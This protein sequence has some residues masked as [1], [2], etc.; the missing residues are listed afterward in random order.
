MDSSMLFQTKSN[1]LD[2]Q[3][4]IHKVE[5][6]KNALI[7]K[8]HRESNEHENKIRKTKQIKKADASHRKVKNKSRS[9]LSE[10]SSIE[11]KAS[12]KSLLLLD[13]S[14]KTTSNT[15]FGNHTFN[16]IN[17]ITAKSKFFA[18][19][20]LNNG[21]SALTGNNN[22]QQKRIQFSTVDM[23][24]NE[25]PQLL[26]NKINCSFSDSMNNNIAKVSS[27][28][29]LDLLLEFRNFLKFGALII[30][31]RS[32]S[33]DN[34]LENTQ[35]S[36]RIFKRLTN[37]QTS[38]ANEQV[39]ANNITEPLRLKS[40]SSKLMRISHGHCITY[41]KLVAFLQKDQKPNANQET[42]KYVDSSSE[43]MS[44]RKLEKNG[45]KDSIIEGVT[46]NVSQLPKKAAGSKKDNI[47]CCLL[48]CF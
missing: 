30:L 35:N 16:N 31:P 39:S 41:N 7:S 15:G 47:K 21:R 6:R 24:F 5:I 37:A 17:K 46:F 27:P 34:H 43:N 33:T 20:K 12:K 45:K 18:K 3:L 1:L 4:G 22:P 14:I 48:S 29:K 28:H 38:K 23:L 26:E 19:P 2:T 9:T 8:Q 32:K 36:I 42:Y 11:S 25:V 44:F 13:E 10:K 40:L